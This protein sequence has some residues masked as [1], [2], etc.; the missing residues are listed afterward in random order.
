[1]GQDVPADGKVKNE[2]GG[3]W[4]RRDSKPKRVIIRIATTEFSG[5]SS[6]RVNFE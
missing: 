6:G 2:A 3:I 5:S 1:M 4:D